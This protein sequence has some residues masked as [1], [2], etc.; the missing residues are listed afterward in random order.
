M[1]PGRTAALLCAAT[2][3]LGV[4]ACGSGGGSDDST[5][6]SKAPPP[7][8]AKAGKD[9]LT[10]PGTQLSL[11]EAA[12]VGWSPPSTFASA[13]MRT[14]IPLEVAV[15]AIQKGTPSDLK[16]VSLDADEKGATPYY[17]M[18]HVTNRGAT[19]P[20]S[21]DPDLTFQAIDDRGQRQPSLTFIGGQ[22][23]R[24]DDRRPPRAFARGKSYD[25]CLTYLMKGGGSIH[26]V[27]WTDGPSSKTSVSAYL[28]K[29]VVWTASTPRPDRPQP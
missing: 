22:F 18:V 13:G 1:T 2:L 4:A 10:P 29:P 23:K 12:D 8:P 28:D 21:D 19:A 7:K 27:R 20:A 16:D 25:S 3:A 17:V 26:E 24:C 14:S 15:S 6:S 11:N 9:G 5:S